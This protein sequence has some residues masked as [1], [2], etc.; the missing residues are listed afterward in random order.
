M[1]SAGDVNGDGYADLLISAVNADDDAGKTY[2]VYGRSNGFPATVTLTNS[3]LNGTNGITLAGAV[4]SIYSGQSVSS[5][6]DVN[7]D[8]YADLLIGAYVANPD[9]R[10]D[11]GETYLVFGRSA[12]L[13]ASIILTNTWLDGT[14]GITL[15]GASGDDRSGCSVSSAGDVN[16]DGYADLLVGAYFA[17]PDG[18]NY[19]GETYLIY[20]RSSGFPSTVT[21]TNSWLDGTNGITLA[22]AAASD[23][24]G[25]SVSSAG[26]INGD[27]YADILIGAYAADPDGIGSAGETYLVY[28]RSNGLSATITLT[29]TWLD[30]TNGITLVGAKG[31]DQSGYSVSSAGDVDRDGYDDLLVGA[32]TADPAGRS[33]AGETYL[34]YGRSSGLPATITLTNAWLNGTNG[35]VLAGGVANYNTGYSVSSAGD[36]NGDSFDDLLVGA[37]KANPDGR[38]YAG[39]TYLIYGT[40]EF[41]PVTPNSGSWTGGYHVLIAGE[42]LGN[43]GDI[44]NV[45]ICGITAG[46]ESQSRTSVTVT[47]GSSLTWQTGDVVVQSVSYGTTVKSNSF[48]YLAPTL[49]ILGTNGA[50][51]ASDD[52]IDLADGSKFRPT[53]IGMALTNTFAITNTGN[54]VLSISSWTTNGTD[55]AFFTLVDVPTSVAIGAVSNFG[56]V[57]NPTVVGTHTATVSFAS[58]DP[59]SP[60]LFNLGGSCFA[61]STNVGPFAGG[62]TLTI[63]NGSFGTITNILVDGVQATLG[64]HGD[65]WFTITLP[66][67]SGAGSVD[68]TVQTSDNGDT[69]LRDAYTYNPA[70]SLPD[71]LPASVTLTNTWL[72]G[73]N[74]VTFIGADNSGFCGCSV[75]CVGDMNSDGIDD[76]LIGAE[77]ADNRVSHAYLVYGR[78]GAYPVDTIL[79][80]TWLNGTNGMWMRGLPYQGYF[81]NAVSGNGDVNG[82]GLSDMMVGSYQYDANS[83]FH[84]GEAFLVY[85]QSDGLPA[86]IAANDS[87]MGTATNAT[88]LG[89]THRL[90]E[91]AT[92]ISFAGDVNGDGLTDLLIGAPKASPGAGRGW[93]GETY[94]V[95]GTT[96]TMPNQVKLTNTWLDGVN[97]IILSGAATNDQSGF[98]V[99][100]AGDVNGDG[101][102]DLLISSKLAD[103][104]GRVSAGEVYLVF[105]STNLAADITLTNTWFDGTNGVLFAGSVSDDN[106][107]T[108]LSAAGDVNGDGLGDF[109]IGAS[110]VDPNGGIMTNAGAT[111]LVYGTTNG[112]PGNVVL[113]NTWF[114]GANGVMLDGAAVSDYSGVSVASGDVNGDG[115]SDVLIGAGYADPDG[116]NGGGE[117]YLVYGRSGLPATI[118]LN[119][120]WLDGTNGVIF[121]GTELQCFAGNAVSSGGDYNDDGYDDILIGAEQ[122]DPEGQVYLVYGSPFPVSPLSGSWTGGYQVVISGQNIG[123][124]DITNVTLCGLSASIVSQ[125]ANR[126]WITAPAAVSG[127]SGDVVVQSVSYGTTIRSNGFTYVAPNL[128]MMGTNGAAIASDDAI[129]LAKGS[130]FYATQIGVAL[131]NTF[132]ITNTGNDVLSISGWTTNG[133]NAGLFTLSGVPSAVAVGGVDTFTVVYNPTAVGSHT[134]TVSFASD[135]PVS[136]FL[137]NLGGSCFAGTTNVGPYAGGNTVTFTNGNFGTITNVLVGGV[138]ATLGAHGANWFTITMPGAATNGP[139]D[140]IVQTDAGYILLTDAYTYNPAGEIGAEDWT[141]WEEVEPLTMP[142][143]QAG[144]GVLND[145]LYCFGG[146]DDLFSPWTNAYAFDGTTWAPV[147]GLSTGISQQ[148]VTTMGGNLYS[149]GGNDG[150]VTRS[151]VWVFD[152][153]SWSDGVNLPLELN[154]HQACALDGSIYVMGGVKG[155]AGTVTYTNILKLN[156]STWEMVRI[157][158]KIRACRR[159]PDVEQPDLCGWGNDGWLPGYKLLQLQRRGNLAESCAGC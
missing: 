108:S 121:A 82:D 25:Y 10:N 24:S 42:N 51:I 112:L 85:G 126:V 148:A 70:G 98:A 14:N 47:A 86:Y 111:Y 36:V 134:A 58:D 18:N 49:S 100:G 129:D 4:D 22:G 35:V 93:A 130:K 69:L 29:N 33:G 1:S 45:T 151:N 32:I 6:G 55:A 13:P 136:P 159:R 20:G 81:G 30:G 117:T 119:D 123:N 19:A 87:Y 75:S 83:Q 84:A 143:M 116:L 150:T 142:L 31:S 38:T 27:G 72:N 105:G 127:T 144:C 115:L 109:L 26:D 88:K 101:L 76:F 120:T 64:A 146:Y 73:T 147:A 124:S 99:S 95:Y 74:G 155:Q 40:H 89:G 79:T 71:A 131:T 62:N 15:A 149:L 39:E 23:Y 28:G 107:G 68:I 118:T 132:A 66:A 135:D 133:A 139:V 77:W 17:D 65:S 78:T 56:V 153:S 21:L 96:N 3:W 41:R 7:G 2:L 158:G 50:A 154:D 128:S 157:V 138:Q 141:H 54:D 12:G 61:G 104:G 11:A 43:G 114:D 8:G 44:T 145:K 46:I 91:A 53:Q 63:T 48:T 122:A 16:G 102:D 156:G 52:A 57:Y 67:A 103:P 140:V 106:C 80:N 152:G 94:L 110:G 113:T 5:A 60:F 37:R 137:F 125:A 34:V 92:S 97:G 90:G 59:V 9:G